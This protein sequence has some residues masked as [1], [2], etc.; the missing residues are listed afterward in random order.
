MCGCGTWGHG[1]V[2]N[3]VVALGWWLHLGVLEVFSNLSDSGMGRQSPFFASLWEPLIARLHTHHREVGRMDL[4]SLSSSVSHFACLSIEKS[5]HANLFELQE[6]NQ[7]RP[8][9]DMLSRVFSNKQCPCPEENGLKLNYKIHSLTCALTFGCTQKKTQNL[10]KPRTRAAHCSPESSL[11]I[12][13]V[14]SSINQKL[15]RATFISCF[16]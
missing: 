13:A 7:I 11:Q 12:D 4:W 14:S 5:P 10:S 3:V 1:L 15:L 9:W 8:F 2:V 6:I 16:L